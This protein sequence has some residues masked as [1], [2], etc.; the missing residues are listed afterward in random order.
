VLEVGASIGIALYP[1]ARHRRAHAAAPRRRGDVHGEA[2]A[3]RLQLPSRRSGSRARPISSRS[4]SSCACAIERNELQLYYQPKLH[5]RTGLMT[6]CEVLMRWNHPRR[7]L[8]GPRSSS[9]SPSARDSFV[10]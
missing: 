3:E 5:M 9:R 8:L 2:E 7:G 1:G 4:S 6:R 10:R